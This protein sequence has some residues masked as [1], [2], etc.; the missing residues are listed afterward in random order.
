MKVVINEKETP[1]KVGY[2]KLMQAIGSGRVVLFASRG[3]GTVVSEDDLGLFN[4]TWDMEL[5][6]PFTGTITLS[7]D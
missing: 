7:N 6:T 1:K 4:D 3:V 2:P 5:F